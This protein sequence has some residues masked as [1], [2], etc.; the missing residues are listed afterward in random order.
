MVNYEVARKLN[1]IF[2]Y[3]YNLEEPTMATDYMEKL[4]QIKSINYFIINWAPP[5]VL[6]GDFLL[7]RRKLF[8]YMDPI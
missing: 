7:C 2:G 1:Q 4:K 3:E 5:L 6:A 8:H